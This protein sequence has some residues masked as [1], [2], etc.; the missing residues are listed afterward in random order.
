M[1]V[2]LKNRAKMT[3]TTMGSTTLPIL[4]TTTMEFTTSSSDLTVATAPTHSITTTTEFSTQMTGTTTTT[5]FSKVQLTLMHSK[6]LAW[7]HAMFRLTAASM[8]TSS[9]RGLDRLSARSTLQIR[10]QWITTTTV[11]PMKTPMARD[12]DDTTKMMTMTHE[13][14]NSSGLVTSITMASRTTSTTMTTVTVLTTSKT[15]THTMHQSQPATQK[16]ATSS[17]QHKLGTSTPTESTR[18]ALT[19]SMLNSTE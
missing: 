16:L 4:T 11:L 10:I 1:P 12:Q 5:E 6:P 14:T 19:S 17:T 3:T 15:P 18:A 13:L 7:T 8:R 9:T 2:C